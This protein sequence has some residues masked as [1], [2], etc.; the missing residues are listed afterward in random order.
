MVVAAA[1]SAGGFELIGGGV[2]HLYHFT[3]VAHGLSGEGVV[4]VHL[5]SGI[6]DVE[7][8][9]EYAVALGCHHG[10]FGTHHNLIGQFAVAF[11]DLLLQHHYILIIAVAESGSRGEGHLKL[12]AGGQILHGGK[13]SRHHVVAYAIHQLIGSILRGLE[14]EFAVGVVVEF[15]FVFH[16]FAGSNSL[17]FVHILILS[18]YSAGISSGERMVEG[19]ASSG[20]RVVE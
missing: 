7:H 10:E 17:F 14:E 12:I 19:R 11:E 18:V 15:I 3:F 20:S 8:A 13:Q 6:A 2:A 9:A 5:Y 1:A 4:E 16:E